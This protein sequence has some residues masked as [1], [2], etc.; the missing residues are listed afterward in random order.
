[1]KWYLYFYF[2]L[3]EWGESSGRSHWWSKWRA[4]TLLL[5]LPVGLGVCLLLGLSKGLHFNPS[6][7]V[8]YFSI[9]MLVAIA[10]IFQSRILKYG[11]QKYES[12]FKH[13]RKEEKDLWSLLT[14]I[15]IFIVWVAVIVSIFTII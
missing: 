15:F 12:T 6:E 13:L 3:V 4:A 9:L 1:M 10:V 11:T 7:A 2:T 8:L 14:P 5:V